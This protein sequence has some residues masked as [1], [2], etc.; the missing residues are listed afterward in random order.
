MSNNKKEQETDIFALVEKDLKPE[1]IKHLFLMYKPESSKEELQAKTEIARMLATNLKS[2]ASIAESRE[3]TKL[4]SYRSYKLEQFGRKK[5]SLEVLG[6]FIDTDKLKKENP[7]DLEFGDAGRKML[8]SEIEAI[9]EAWNKDLPHIALSESVKYFHRLHMISNVY[10]R[11]FGIANSDF[12]AELKASTD[13]QAKILYATVLSMVYAERKFVTDKFNDTKNKII[14]KFKVSDSI[15]NFNYDHYREYV[16]TGTQALVYCL[17]AEL[18]VVLGA[19]P[20]ESKEYVPEALRY[21][22]LAHL[23]LSMI[24]DLKAEYRGEDDDEDEDYNYELSDT[25]IHRDWNNILCDMNDY[26]NHIERISSMISFTIRTHSPYTKDKK[27]NVKLYV[28]DHLNEELNGISEYYTDF[29][30]KRGIN[31]KRMNE[32][33]EDNF[34]NYCGLLIKFINLFTTEDDDFDSAIDTLVS[35]AKSGANK[36][37]YDKLKTTN[38]NDILI[39]KDSASYDIQFGYVLNTIK[40]VAVAHRY[41]IQHNI[42]IV[43]SVEKETHDK[44]VELKTSFSIYSANKIKNTKISDK[45]KLMSDNAERFIKLLDLFIENFKTGMEKKVN[46]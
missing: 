7:A 33:R 45:A 30:E 43:D 14:K 6:D 36:E 5:L 26:P 4:R 11:R 40:S 28:A 18:D 42:T 22:E 17:D 12:I 15:V 37:A 2:V 24:F 32:I 13:N 44:L 21:F 10:L 3:S 19:W 25:S 38:W 46:E 8:I 35:D 29:I 39:K 34:K 41:K 27:D 1:Q 20:W 23:L 9:F 16:K 31:S